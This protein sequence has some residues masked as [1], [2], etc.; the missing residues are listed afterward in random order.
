[1]PDHRSDQ[2]VLPRATL[3][4]ARCWSICAGHPRR[5][6]SFTAGLIGLDAVS[7][8]TR[9]TSDD[10]DD[11]G[12]SP[13]G[14]ADDHLILRSTS[15]DLTVRVL[16]P[17]TGGIVST[18]PV[19]IA[20]RY[21]NDY[22]LIGNLLV[23][24]EPGR[25][26]AR[27][28]VTGAVRWAVG[29]DA[30]VAVMA[31]PGRI[32]TRID[33]YDEPNTPLA[34]RS[35]ADGRLEWQTTLDGTYED[36]VDTSRFVEGTAVVLTTTGTH[37]VDLSTGVVR[38]RRPQKPAE[39]ILDVGTGLYVP[40]EGPGVILAPDTGEVLEAVPERDDG[41]HLLHV[42]DSGLLDDG[43]AVVADL[44]RVVR[45]DVVAQSTLVKASDTRWTTETMAA[46]STPVVAGD[47]AL[48]GTPMGVRAYNLE[49]GARSWAFD[50]GVPGSRVRTRCRS[51]VGR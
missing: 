40:A 1:M 22:A 15:D 7:G 20:G 46:L 23:S 43:T 18:Y 28:A 11:K 49:N 47:L 29:Q 19:P 30:D 27:E 36:M 35:I 2:R 48:V 5:R 6:P 13:L 16:D 17:A 24:Y 45:R 32:L 8:E 44:S 10:A 42:T 34:R 4:L 21:A 14:I 12:F 26:V 41:D 31:D 37:S 3:S 33:T 50:V 38:W 25:L 51:P 9:W 39:R